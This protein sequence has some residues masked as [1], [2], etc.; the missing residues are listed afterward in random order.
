MLKHETLRNLGRAF[1]RRLE[2]KAREYDRLA[3]Y[4][5]TRPKQGRAQWIGQQ[6]QEPWINIDLRRHC[7]I[8]K[9]ADRC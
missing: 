4:Q 1:N 5:N 2:E 9:Q 8:G 3:K 6:A 7:G